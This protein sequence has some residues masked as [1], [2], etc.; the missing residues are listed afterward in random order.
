[1][2]NAQRLISQHLDLAI[3]FQTYEK[4]APAIASLFRSANIP[5]IAIEIPHP[6]AIYFGIDNYRAGL[7]AGRALAKS[8]KMCWNGQIDEILLLEL[9]IAGCLPHLRL[10]GAEAALRESIP[11]NQPIHH[12]DTR[13][14]FLRAFD[15]VRK[16]LQFRPRRRTLVTGVNDPSVLGALRAF[17]EAGRSDRCLGVGLGAIPEARAELRRPGTRLVCSIAFFPEKYGE[18]LMQLAV[19]VVNGRRV[20]TSVYTAVETITPQNVDKIYPADTES[21]GFDY[22]I[23]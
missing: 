5:L 12:L 19:D 10:T 14:E 8:A 13:G 20:P 7:C 3:E 15:A 22:G 16:Y 6:G 9:D 18:G 11:G 1:M 17:E 21:V 4:A 23:R 2:R